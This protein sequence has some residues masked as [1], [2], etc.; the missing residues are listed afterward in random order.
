MVVDSRRT[1]HGH[2]SLHINGSTVEI[3][4]STKFL[5]AHLAEDLTWSLNT[6]TITKKA[7]QRLYFLN[8][9]SGLRASEN[10]TL[11]E[12]WILWQQDPEAYTAGVSSATT[13]HCRKRR[14]RCERPQERGTWAGVSARLKGSQHRPTLPSILLENVRTLENKMDYLRLDLTM[15]R[16]RPLLTSS[17][18]AEKQTRTCPEGA[19]SALQDCPECTDWNMFR[20]AAT[21]NHHIS[22]EEYA[23]SMTGYMSKCVEDVTVTR[24][25]TTRA[26]QKPWLTREVHAHLRTRNAAF[27]PGD[28]N[29]LRS[30]RANLNRSVRAA[31]LAYG[32][33]IQSHFTDSKDSRRLWQGIQSSTDCHAHHPAMTALTSLTYSTPTSAGSGESNTTP[34]RKA[35][36]SPECSVLTRMTSRGPCV[37]QA[38]VPQCFKATTILPL[39]MKSSASSPNDYRPIALTPIMMKCFERLVKDHITSRLP[40]TFDPLQFAYRSS[41]DAISSA[42][43]LSLTYLENKN[44]Y[45]WMLFTDF[46]SAFKTVIPQHLVD[47]PQTIR[48]GGNTSK[49]TTM[50]TGV[51]QGCVLNPLLFT[52]LTHDCCAKYNSNHIIR[53]ADDT[54]VVGLISNDDESAYREEEGT[55]APSLPTKDEKS[56]PSPLHPHNILQRNSR[57]HSDQ[58]PHCLVWQLHRLR[59]DITSES[60]WYVPVLT[61]QPNRP[62]IFS[63]ETVILTCSIPGKTVDDWRYNW[64]RDNTP[65]H[66]SDLHYYIITDIKVSQSSNYYCYV[67]VKHG[68]G[69]SDWSN[70]VTLTVT[71]RPKASLT[72]VPTGQMFKGET[73]TLRCDIQGHTDT[74]WSYSWYKDGDSNRPVHSSD[75]KTDYSF[76]AVESDSGTYTCRGERRRDSQRSEISNTVTLTVSAE[77]PKPELTSSRKGAALIGSPVV[78]Y[79]KLDQSAGWKLYWS[80]HTQNPENETETETPSYTISSVSVSDGGQYWCRAGRGDPVYY[81]HYSDALWIN[82]TGESPPVS[83]MVSP[84]RTQ[85]FTTD[86]LSL[87]CE[88]QSDSTGW[89]VRRFTHSEKVSDCSSGWRSVTGST[90]NISSLSTSHT[91]VYWCESES[92][93]SSNPVNITVHSG[94]VILESPVHPVPEGD[95]L[96]LHCLYH[97]TNSSNLT[98]EFYKDGSLLQT[99]TTGEMTIRTVSK[100]DEGLY[101]CKHPERGKSPQSWISVRAGKSTAGLVGVAVGVSVAVLF[102]LLVTL[103]CCYKAKKGNQQNVNQTSDQNQRESGEDSQSGCTPLQAGDAADELKD[104]IYTEVVVKNKR[105]KD[106][107]QNITEQSSQSHVIYSNLPLDK[108]TDV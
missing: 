53:S 70:A 54:T 56:K 1:R 94:A 36:L 18:P 62:Q 31:K 9:P 74:G 41:D 25:I 51:P 69:V 73:V 50:N 22:L 78:L 55:A 5:G 30:A 79:C 102:I 75:D 6:S 98:A 24:N 12:L 45:V 83:L 100:S 23:E 80:K 21:V 46:S 40:A 44:S 29:A 27:K 49:T 77:R 66:H 92:G 14:K 82:T 97:H 7:Q 39:P 48:V 20:E 35:P 57:E 95:P 26:N 13:N 89:R 72:M 71:E 93:G 90:C 8:L 99:Q 86:P 105:S 87:S 58:Q 84:S 33:K 81:S 19:V 37:S 85:H 15:Q 104:V 60:G 101:H 11:C 43:H 10:K 65:L 107:G 108:A 47:R 67:S 63:G 17:K 3:V 96:T 68:R 106:K 59:P 42:L 4:K 52:L 64:Y 103:L 61:V 76:S 32:Q 16:Y 91:G 88:G 34:I 28:K 2:S 38:I